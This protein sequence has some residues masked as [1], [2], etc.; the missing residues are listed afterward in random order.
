MCFI[1]SAYP[2]KSRVQRTRSCAAAPE[3][4][5]KPTPAA[6]LAEKTG[7]HHTRPE[8]DD[9]EGDEQAPGLVA[10]G[11]LGSSAWA[12]VVDGSATRATA[13]LH[14]RLGSIDRVRAVR[15]ADVIDTPCGVRRSGWPADATS[16]PGRRS[17]RP[18]R[19]LVHT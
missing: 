6:G 1:D 8:R 3:P 19:V 4:L 12:I 16:R 11:P 14:L 13:A 5:G 15:P 2:P 9:P 17:R 10:I 18:D 7:T